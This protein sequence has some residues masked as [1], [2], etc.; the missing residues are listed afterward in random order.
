MTLKSGTQTHQILTN[1]DEVCI[2]NLSSTL[3]ADMFGGSG[4]WL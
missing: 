3:P 2:P 4:F 1:D